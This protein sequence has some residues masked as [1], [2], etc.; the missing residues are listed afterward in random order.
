MSPVIFMLA[1][2]WRSTIPEV[3]G[4]PNKK[5][6]F[7]EIQLRQARFP[8]RMNSRLPG[9]LSIVIAGRVKWHVGIG[10]VMTQFGRQTKDLLRVSHQEGL[11]KLPVHPLNM[12]G[13]N[14]VRFQAISSKFQDG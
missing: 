7:A 12:P 1:R 13:H 3:V 2:N 5:V 11:L 8:E 6:V 10:N 4:F 14:T 9:L